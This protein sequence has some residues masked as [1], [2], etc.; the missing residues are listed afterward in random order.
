MNELNMPTRAMDTSNNVGIG[1][2][3]SFLEALE[4]ALKTIAKKWLKLACNAGA[5]GTKDLYE[6]VLKMVEEKNHSLIN[7]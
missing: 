6:T 7:A 5:V 3:E 4:P 1:Y 2:E